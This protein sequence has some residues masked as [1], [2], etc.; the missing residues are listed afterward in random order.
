M[1]LCY[2]AGYLDAYLGV[3]FCES[4]ELIDMRNEMNCL[5]RF[6]RIA[7]LELSFARGVIIQVMDWK[8]N[9]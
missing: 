3:L 5:S 9:V 8:T 6:P 4:S 1:G 7:A 2:N